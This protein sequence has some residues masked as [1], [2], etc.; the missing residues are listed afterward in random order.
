MTCIDRERADR[1]C[2]RGGRLHFNITCKI[3]QGLIL[4]HRLWLS[5]MLI[6]TA[7]NL[8]LHGRGEKKSFVLSI[9]CHHVTSR[10]G[11]HSTGVTCRKR[12]TQDLLKGCSRHFMSG[13]R[14][15]IHHMSMRR[16]TERRVMPQLDGFII[17]TA[18]VLRVLYT[19]VILPACITAQMC[20]TLQKKGICVMFRDKQ[21]INTQHTTLR[22]PLIIS[23]HAACFQKTPG[24]VEVSVQVA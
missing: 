22:F 24:L 17:P 20:L 23:D 19:T 1:F 18:L 13:V 8:T 15:T 5:L 4:K 12:L 11:S 14:G 6:V 2:C 9:Y 21:V 3:N 16:H 10:P 7:L